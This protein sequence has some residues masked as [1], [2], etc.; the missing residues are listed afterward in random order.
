VKRL[1]LIVA[2]SAWGCDAGN[3]GQDELSDGLA[4]TPNQV[5]VGGKTV[6]V[7]SDYL[8]RV[9]TC[10]DGHSPPEALKAQAIAARTYLTSRTK[11]QA[12]PTIRDGTSDQVYSCPASRTIPAESL[13]AVQATR[14]MIMLHD[15]R[16]ITGNFV[17]GALRD[18]QCRKTSDATKTERFVT[19][20][21]GKSGD[22]VH[23]SSIAGLSNSDNRGCMSQNMANCLA[24]Q[25]GLTY[26]Q[27]LKYFYGADITIKGG[28]NDPP[29][30]DL[31]NDPDQGQQGSAT[32]PPPPTTTACR[33][34][35]TDEAIPVGTCF[36]SRL[37][38]Q[39]YQCTA[40]GTLSPSVT[41]GAGPAGQCT[42]PWNQT[43]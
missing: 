22:Q 10:E 8:P 40:D 1:M 37:D 11:G 29:D 23:P 14:G 30:T 2:L 38:A 4:D 13:A 32:P 3:L 9:V 28:A 31:P 27:I 7:E 21:N 16:V 25:M 18:S 26:P 39:W 24:K 35:D 20:N 36:V 34:P 12:V 43:F 6:D 41:D 5:H 17:A 42:T 19:L 33:T 15:G